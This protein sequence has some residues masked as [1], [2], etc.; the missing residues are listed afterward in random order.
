M[1]TGSVSLG[2]TL[3]CLALAH[4]HTKGRKL[5]CLRV[6]NGAS[7][8]SAPAARPCERPKLPDPDTQKLLLQCWHPTQIVKEHSEGSRKCTLGWT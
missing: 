2:S 6:P 5:K 3:G 7:C 1:A 4:T 8:D